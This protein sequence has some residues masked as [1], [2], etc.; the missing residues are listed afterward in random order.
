MDSKSD[1][2]NFGLLG[3]CFYGMYELGYSIVEEFRKYKKKKKILEKHGE[4]DYSLEEMNKLPDGEYVLF[5]G[6]AE[7]IYQRN[8]ELLEKSVILSFGNSNYY[9]DFFL[10]TPSCKVVIQPYPGCL[11]HALEYKYLT[12]YGMHYFLAGIL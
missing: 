10:N 7:K 12:E 4:K 2:I 5:G 1:F 11:F 9:E 6:S 8:S 3:M